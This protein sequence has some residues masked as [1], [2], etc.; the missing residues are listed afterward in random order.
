MRH[1]WQSG[2]AGVA[3]GSA[4]WKQWREKPCGSFNGVSPGVTILSATG[5]WRQ[6]LQRE[7][8]SI[9]GLFAAAAADH[10]AL[11]QERPQTENRTTQTRHWEKADGAFWLYST[12]WGWNKTQNGKQQYTLLLR[13]RPLV[14]MRKRFTESNS[15]RGVCSFTSRVHQNNR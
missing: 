14:N 8:F 4:K 13:P 11:E 5:S 3:R 9:R 15:G 7:R 6:R 2:K 10:T 12:L 1:E